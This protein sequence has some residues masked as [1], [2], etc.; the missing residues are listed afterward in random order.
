MLVTNI[1]VFQVSC[2]F[3]Q[4]IR[5]IFAPFRIALRQLGLS[6]V[7]QAGAVNLSAGNQIRAICPS[8]E[9]WLTLR[10]MS[11]KEF[12]YHLQESPLHRHLTLNSIVEVRHPSTDGCYLHHDHFDD[13]SGAW[14]S[15][16]F[17]SDFIHACTIDP[18]QDLSLILSDSWSRNQ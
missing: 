7:P 12:A 16:F 2:Q 14:L 13:V 10:H 5:R 1:L 8:S 9:N 18:V 4:I 6:Y 15:S 3:C 11:V 17:L